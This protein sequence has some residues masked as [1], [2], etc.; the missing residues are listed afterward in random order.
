M[1]MIGSTPNNMNVEALHV[2]LQ[3]SFH[4][5]ASVRDPAEKMIQNLKYVNGATA[6][7]LQVAAEKQVAFEVR[8][9][10]AIQLKNICRDCWVE[11]V[12]FSGTPL[13]NIHN[14]NNNTN[15]T[16]SSSTPVPRMSEHDQVL[17][18]NALMDALLNEHETSV[19]DL[20]AETLHHISM[21]D[22]PLKWPD[23]LPT[24]LNVIQSSEALRVHNALLALRKICK[25][26]EYKA[27]EHRGPLNEV[28]RQSFGLLLPLAK[29]LSAE[30][31]LEAALMLKQILKI[32]WSSTQFYLPQHVVAVLSLATPSRG[33]GDA[34]R[35]RVGVGRDEW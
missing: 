35:D 3:Q 14:K 20:L 23:L 8:Q 12:G 26:Y 22:Y 4:P 21:H 34:K 11:R 16:S 33:R 27:K 29:R 28:V 13:D 25:R 10:A 2:A 6:M 31:S 30:N 18:K 1:A 9:A 19:R 32:F 17:V 15:S 5:D 24:L 7:L